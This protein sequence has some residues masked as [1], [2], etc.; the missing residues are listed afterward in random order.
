MRMRMKMSKVIRASITFDYYPEED[1]LMEGMT[2]A[3]ML[4]YV[5]SSYI[6]D[7]YSFVKYNELADAVEV[8]I[9]SEAHRVYG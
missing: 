2:E 9:L 1:E 6:D 8:E 4:E 7:I 5:K 3:E